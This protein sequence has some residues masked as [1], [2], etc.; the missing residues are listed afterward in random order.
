MDKDNSA[1]VTYT[2]DDPQA[3]TGTTKRDPSEDKEYDKKI[4]PKLHKKFK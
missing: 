4:N 3:K 2:L 1:H